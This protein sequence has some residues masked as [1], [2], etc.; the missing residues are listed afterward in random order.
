MSKALSLFLLLVTYHVF[1]QNEPA[2]SKFVAVDEPA[3][4]PGGMKKFYQYIS[5]NLIYPKAAKENKLEG[6]VYVE[7]TID[8][9]G[10]VDTASV[11]AVSGEELASHNWMKGQI[12][13]NEECESEAIRLLRASPKWNPGMSRGKPVR[14]KMVLPIAF[15]P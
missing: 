14:Q 13:E 4:F 7:F 2:Q 6:R 15:R 11:R 10:T 12:I 1:A 5:K 8:Q 9:D 3:T